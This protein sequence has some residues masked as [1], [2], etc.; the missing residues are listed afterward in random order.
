MMLL[1]LYTTMDF[2]VIITEDTALRTKDVNKSPT[3][4]VR[5]DKDE[6]VRSK[7][8]AILPQADS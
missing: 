7:D 6:I 8:E 5:S 4:A 1:F 3:D 2:H